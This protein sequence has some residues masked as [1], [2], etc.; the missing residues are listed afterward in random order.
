MGQ[1]APNFGLQAGR[2]KMTSVFRPYALLLFVP[3]KALRARCTANLTQDL[4]A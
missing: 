4:V 1:V 3:V 2:R